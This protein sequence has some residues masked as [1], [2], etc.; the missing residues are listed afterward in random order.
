MPFPLTL[1]T[2]PPRA[3]ARIGRNRWPAG[4]S[5][6]HSGFSTMELLI[7]TALLVVILVVLFGCFRT[8]IGSYSSVSASVAVQDAARRALDT[9]TRDLR[10]G[11]PVTV[12]AGNMQLNFQIALSFDPVACPAPGTCWGARDQTGVDRLGWQLQ[13]RLN[14]LPD[15]TTQ[16][17]RETRN[18]IAPA[19]ATVST[20]VLANNVVNTAAQPIFTPVGTDVVIIQLR[21]QQSSQQLPGG[22]ASTG[23]TPV[24]ARVKLRNL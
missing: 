11:G 7:A 15:G 1:R 2:S 21:V 17:I 24:Q 3:S 19:G 10:S 5:R 9:M 4:V 20:R 16:L 18:G 12:S 13:Y 23:T 14:A 8:S 22:V 6:A